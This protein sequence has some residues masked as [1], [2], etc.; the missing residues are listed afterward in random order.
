[1]D[2]LGGM[3]ENIYKLLINNLTDS[4]FILQ[5][6]Q[7]IFANHAA[8]ESWGFTEEELISPDFDFMT[9]IHPDYRDHVREKIGQRPAQR[10]VCFSD[11]RMA[12]KSGEV[13]RVTFKSIPITNEG[14][15]AIAVI[16]ADL[17]K[18]K[19]AEESCHRSEEQ[20]HELIDTFVDAV[21]SVDTRMKIVRW[22][23]GAERLFGYR[24]DEILGE[25]L[26]KIV[27]QKYRD[28]KR[29]GFIHFNRTGSGPVIG[30]TLELEG[31]KKDGTLVPVELSV[32]MSEA[33]GEYIATAIVRDI[34][35][36]KAIEAE[37]KCAQTLIDSISNFAGIA[38]RD[39]RL[40]FVNKRALEILDFTPEE[41]IGKFFWEC[42]WFTSSEEI[43]RIVRSSIEASLSGRTQHSEISVFTKRGDRISIYFTTTPIYDDDENV[44]GVALEGVD[45]TKLKEVEELYRTIINA[46]SAAKEGFALVQD[47][48]GIEAKHVFVNDYYAELTG[49]TKEEL[50]AMSGLD[51]IH[52][53]IKDEVVDR[54]RRKMAGEDLP[55]YNEFEW[56]RKDGGV[57]SV[58]LSS[59]VAT[60]QG[61]PAFLY[62]FRDITEEKKVQ[63][64]LDNYRLHLEELVFER[65]QELEE[66]YE[67]LKRG[68]RLATIGEL[69]GT[70]AH[71]IRN[72]LGAIK[73]SVYYLDMVLASR[74]EKIDKHLF[75]MQQEISRIDKLISDLL[76][77]SRVKTPIK[78][79]LII[80]DVINSAIEKVNIPPEVNVVIK[81]HHPIGTQFCA[82]YHQLERVFLNLLTNAADAIEDGGTI[83]IRIRDEE[84]VAIMVS[85]TGCGIKKEVQDKIF[86]PL[87]TTKVH[88]VGL[89]LSICRQIVEAHGGKIEVES[90]EGAGTTFIMRFPRVI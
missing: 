57:R 63:A 65:T 21:I 22:N 24:E 58:G 35:D 61:K 17:T 33:G 87:Y 41:V 85:D 82:D 52:P 30:K 37:I 28:L 16:I 31:L 88:G 48:D 68:E 13:R 7:I 4:V 2:E 23:K 20:L 80:E 59:A 54:Y 73:N 11:I 72:P 32:S 71:E 75:L 40:T 34:S 56:V 9:L 69:A 42:Q 3:T 27:P 79:K 49:Y 90:C 47:I 77:F 51:I 44:V 78:E 29:K 50:Y 60:Y 15:P 70:F 43:K 38:D 62:Y 26:M 86:E 6:G 5:G 8:I 67:R 39:G 81:R 45:I 25:S 14:M 83:E 12:R 10:D 89:G 19:V 36:R 84:E 66:V 55:P 74:S 76:H 18:Q 53:A 64:V 46:G 1:T